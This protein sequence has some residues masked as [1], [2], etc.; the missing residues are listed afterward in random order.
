MRKQSP[1]ASF[2]L[3][4]LCLPNLASFAADLAPPRP[5]QPWIPATTASG[6]IVAGAPANAP[7]AQELNFVLPAN[8][9]LGLLPEPLTLE[10]G[11]AYA[12]ADLIEIALSRHPTTRMAWNESRQAALA[13]A[14]AQSSFYPKINASLIGA[15]QASFKHSRVEG[16]GGSSE[17]TASGS[18]AALSLEWLLFDFGARAAMLRVAE[19]GAVIANI[20]FM[21][22]H[23]QLIYGIVS[24]YYVHAAAQARVE[25][26]TQSLQN[27]KIIQQAAEARRHNGIG[28]VMEVAQARQAYAQANL[29]LVQA[30][31]ALENAYL[32]LLSAMGISP[33]S[34]FKIA[35]AAGRQLT[36]TLLPAV[37]QTLTAALSRR[38][39]VLSA[40]AAQAASQAHI[41]A[42]QAE[43]KPK[44]F[45]VTSL[46]QSAGASSTT[47]IPSLGPLAPTLDLNGSRH[48]GQIFLGVTVPLYD[49]GARSTALAKAKI[50]AENTELHLSRTKDEAIRQ[51]VVARNALQSHL[52]AYSAAEALVSAT[53]TTYEA[54]LAAYQHGVGSISEVTSAQTQLLVAKNTLADSYSATLTAAATLALATGALGKAP[55]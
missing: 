12:L 49:A 30:N 40:Y 51:V 43:F 34:K 48:S 17:T 47:L 22:S 24:A 28:T 32:G 27:A 35:S 23:Q 38:P 1:M 2:A 5:D 15:G 46:A 55:E 53:Q 37:E 6:Q 39:D 36:P 44:V 42:V 29:A 54:A 45:V 11:K 10:A 33:L 8:D 31:G 7:T 14:A 13:V 4:A 25:S 18:V 19:Q 16:I 9:E 26:A 50:A 21:A 41:E 20:A 52:A 3:A